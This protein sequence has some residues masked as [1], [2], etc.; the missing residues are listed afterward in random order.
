MTLLGD[1]GE[2][3]TVRALTYLVTAGYADALG[4]RLRQ[5]RLFTDADQSAG[6]RPVIVNE[7][8]ARTHL[9]DGRAVVGRR[10]R[11]PFEEGVDIEI[12]GVVAN[13]LKDGLDTDPRPEMYHIVRDRSGWPGFF[14][15]AIR[16]AGD[17]AALAGT[18]RAAVRELDSAA[19]I[20]DVVALDERLAASVSGPRFAAIVLGVFALV[21]LALAAVGLYGVQSY[22]VSQRRRELGVR[23][24]LGAS[25]ASLMALVLRQGVGVALAGLA[26]GALAAAWLST[27]IEGLLFGVSPHDPPVFAGS[28]IV[29]AAVA[30][31][32]TL[33]PAR[34][35]SLVDPIDALKYE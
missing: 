34:K 24:A 13:V 26:L 4:L 11:H 27:R 35:A 12:V 18:L 10:F 21:A 25:P 2:P 19:A 33:L 6:V 29:L 14:N 7:E 16:T 23:A 1:G 9:S 30:I 20:D 28:A 17:P 22:Q 32:A 31:A 3:I 15:V 8:L 5:G